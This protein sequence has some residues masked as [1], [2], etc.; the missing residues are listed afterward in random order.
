MPDEQ[1]GEAGGLQNTG[2]QLGASIG[3]AL[4][5]AVLISAL[6]ASFLTGV[7]DNPAVPDRVAAQAQTNLAAGV[8]FMSDADL[9]TALAD[10]HVPSRTADAIVAT[11]EQSRIDGLRVAVSILALFSLS[12]C[13]SPAASPRCN[14]APKQSSRRRRQSPARAARCR[15]RRG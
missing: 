7:Q 8:P 5:G 15:P 10:A 11:N 6:T 14:R 12:R 13:S 9:Q 1:S 2:T 4:A 3:T